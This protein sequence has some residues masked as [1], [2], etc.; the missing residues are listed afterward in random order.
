MRDICLNC[1]SEFESKL[2]GADCTACLSPNVVH[3]MKCM[4]CDNVIGFLID[5]DYCVPEKLY[6]SDCMKKRNIKEDLK[7]YEER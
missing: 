3:Q 2:F 7:W 4:N 6:C 1:G 5:D